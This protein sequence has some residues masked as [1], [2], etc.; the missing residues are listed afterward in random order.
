[1]TIDNIKKSC[2]YIE[3]YR[4]WDRKSSVDETWANFKLHFTRAFK[5][6]RKSMRTNQAGGYVSNVDQANSNAE[7]F[8]EIQQDHTEALVNLAAATRSDREA[9]TILSKTIS[10]LTSQITT[11]TKI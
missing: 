6:V 5:E 9:V 8:S 3:D 7:L 1:M 11:L 4:E 10:K 2:L